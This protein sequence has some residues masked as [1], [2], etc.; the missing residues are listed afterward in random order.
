MHSLKGEDDGIYIYIY[1]KS[2]CD[3]LVVVFLA[4]TDI[5]LLTFKANISAT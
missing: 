2:Q 3:S 1:I 4:T 5:Q